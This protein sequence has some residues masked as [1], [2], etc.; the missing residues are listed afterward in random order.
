MT[1]DAVNY[2]S[3]PSNVPP[4]FTFP[5][6]NYRVRVVIV[7]ISLFLFACLYMGFIAGSAYLCYIS[8]ASLN[9]SGSKNA[10]GRNLL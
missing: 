10:T 2:P 5:T 7:L 3:S 8:F 6:T 9:P 4:D 1:D